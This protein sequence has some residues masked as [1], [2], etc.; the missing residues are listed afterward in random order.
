MSILDIINE[1][2][3][4]LKE[5]QYQ[6]DL[7]NYVFNLDAYYHAANITNYWVNLMISHPDWSVELQ[8]KHYPT[9]LGDIAYP[10][11]C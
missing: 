2:E 7:P 9:K 11:S 4:A 6:R 3:Q 5:Q 10:V 8:A 1:Y